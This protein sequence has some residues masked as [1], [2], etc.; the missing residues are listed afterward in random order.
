MIWV[1]A[2]GLTHRGSVP[3]LRTLN[4]TKLRLYFFS[5]GD[6]SGKQSPQT[7]ECR[8]LWQWPQEGINHLWDDKYISE[9]AGW[10]PYSCRFDLP[11]TLWAPVNWVKGMTGP[12]S[13]TCERLQRSPQRDCESLLVC[14]HQ[15]LE[16][17]SHH[18]VAHT[19]RTSGQPITMTALATC[20]Q[21]AAL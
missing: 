10:V 17:S 14:L 9:K 5:G 7:V 11:S 15:F 21:K 8:S 2:E 1:T 20:I 6:R 3:Q 16:A 19:H 13:Q 12:I 4:A 18:P